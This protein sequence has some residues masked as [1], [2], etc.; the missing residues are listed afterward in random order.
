MNHHLRL[1]KKKKKK[2][3]R[4]DD[5]NYQSKNGSSEENKFENVF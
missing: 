3:P 1:K 4:C 2:Q 5:K